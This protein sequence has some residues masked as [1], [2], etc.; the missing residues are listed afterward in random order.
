MSAQEMAALMD[1]LVTEARASRDRAFNTMHAV[2]RESQRA[3]QRLAAQVTRFM[4]I[5]E[6]AMAQLLRTEVPRLHA[7]QTSAESD[8]E[9]TIPAGQPANERDTRFD[10]E[11]EWAPESPPPPPPAAQKAAL[12]RRFDHDDED[13]P[14]TWLR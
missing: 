5:H 6:R 3:T 4:G 11:D 2:D 14:E 12:G 1:G 10:P 8:E 9:K 7:E 13:Y